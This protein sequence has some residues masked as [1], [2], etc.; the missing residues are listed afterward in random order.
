MSKPFQ[1]IAIRAFNDNYI[2]CLRNDRSAVVVDPGD[3]RPVLDYLKREGLALAGI[4]ATHHHAD[5]VGGVGTL[6]ASRPVPMYAPHDERIN[7]VTHRVAEP[8]T[9]VLPDFGLAL[10]V[11][12]IPGHTASHVAYYG[13]KLLFCGDTLFACGCGRLFEGTPPQM[14]ASLRKLADLPDDVLVYCGHEYTLSNLRFARL[15]D[16]KNP[17]L[18]MWEAEAEAQRRQGSPTL[19]S[20]LGREKRAN[21]FLR[22]TDPVIIDAASKRAGRALTDPASVFGVLREWK[23]TF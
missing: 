17:M 2:W 7:H 15:V 1:V 8:D 21:P 10:T 18:A 12:E 5:H 20:L 13:A 16:P 9:I 23:N 4:L 22:W 3:A 19:P 11:L 14:V 6:V